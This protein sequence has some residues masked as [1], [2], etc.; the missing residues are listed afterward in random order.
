MSTSSRALTNDALR[1]TGARSSGHLG[2]WRFGPG[3]VLASSARE[4]SPRAS[5]VDDDDEAAAASHAATAW[6]AAAANMLPLFCLPRFG[7]RMLAPALL[8][9]CS[10][11]LALRAIEGEIS[12][13]SRGKGAMGEGGG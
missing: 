13:A 8:E 7:L 2:S 11:P 5:S 10:R 1:E 12:P 6:A 3:S 4:R 9:R